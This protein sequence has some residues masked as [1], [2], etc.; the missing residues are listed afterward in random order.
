MS[1]VYATIASADHEV[2]QRLAA[3]LER[4]A[5]D[6][7]QQG[8]LDDYLTD[9]KFPPDADVLDAGCGT[10]A[11][12][13]VLARYSGVGRVVGV[14]PSSGLIPRR[15]SWRRHGNWLSALTT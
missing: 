2:Q 12:S 5:G 14:D 8:M 4:R 1:D 10:G 15:C 13:R 9:I 6:P 7:Q 3:V 11:V